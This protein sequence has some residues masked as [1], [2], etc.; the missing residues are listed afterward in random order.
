VTVC[1][2]TLRGHKA[3]QMEL[4]VLGLRAPLKLL[5]KAQKCSLEE[6]DHARICDLVV[7]LLFASE[8]C[9]NEAL[10]KL[11]K[12]I[13]IA[14]RGLGHAAFAFECFNWMVGRLTA[15]CWKLAE[16]CYDSFLLPIHA[17]IRC[18]NHLGKSLQHYAAKK[19]S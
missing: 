1:T 11:K 14:D 7:K 4:A 9:T 13:N 18:F 2:L 15:D 5:E 3:V 6:I 10:K 17:F 19:N 16:N 12:L 8:L